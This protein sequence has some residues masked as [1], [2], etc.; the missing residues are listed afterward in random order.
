MNRAAVWSALVLLF[1]GCLAS[2]PSAFAAPLAQ[3]TVAWTGYYFA[4]RNLQGDPVFVREDADINF[5]WGNSAPA[6]GLPA[7]DFSVRW[8]RWLYID[9]AGDWTFSLMADDGVRLFVDDM[10]VLDEWADQPPLARSVS[11]PL[12]QSFHLFRVEYYDHTGSAQVQFQMLSANYP[13]WR[14]EYYGSLDLSSTPAFVR[15]DSAVNFNFGTTGPG[16]GVPGSNF[17]VRWMRGQF[18]DAGRYRFTTTTDDGVRLWVDNQLLVDQWRDQTTKSWSGDIALASG[19]HLIRMEYFNHG[20]AAL[21]TLT[22]SLVPGSGELW[23]SDYFDNTALGGT[24]DLSRDT[25]DIHYDWG[26]TAPG[27]G[28]PAGGNWSAR[29]TSR[30]VVSLAGYYTVSAMADD[31][32]RV[33][34]DNEVLI[35][36]WHDQPATPHAATAFLNPGAHDWRVDFYQH[37]GSASLHVQIT[38]G[39]VAPSLEELESPSTGDVIVDDNAAGFFK[40]GATDGWRELKSGYGGHALWAPSNTFS[41][42]QSNWA[43]WY[44]PL[45]RAGNYAISVYIP[46]NT[47][48]TQAARYSIQHAGAN[49][50]VQISQALYTDQW[51]SLGTFYFDALGDEYVGLTDVTF[52]PS[53]TTKLAVDAIRFSPR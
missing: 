3:S 43:R 15:N 44:P 24:P 41:Q 23:H 51:V 2:P 34:L 52:E 5:A 48:T 27:P 14:G 21:A 22:W 25:A 45:P 11:I 1:V 30:R 8:T 17:A 29:F 26:P 12:T 39:V 13:D 49:D 4:N 31:G 36:E 20:G 28:I 9:A 46:A 33:W 19:T 47:A 35:D 50:L 18:F 38:P 32:M 10:L 16:G 42:P 37:S 53:Q 40:G 6:P 7:D